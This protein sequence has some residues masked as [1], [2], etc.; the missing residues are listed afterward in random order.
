MA[1]AGGAADKLPNRYEHWWT[2][3]QIGQLLRGEASSMRLEPP[4]D[5]GEGIE[6]E[7]QFPDGPCCDQVKDS[8][9]RWTLLRLA[10][11]LEK[12]ARHLAGGKTVRLILSTDAGELESL[13]ERAVAAQTFAEFE[14]IRTKDQATE[15]AAVRSNWPEA[16]EENAWRYLRQI[17]VWHQPGESLRREVAL[18]YSFLVQDDAETVVSLLRA[19]CDDHLHQVVTAPQIWSYLAEKKVKR[20]YLIGDETTALALSDSVGRFTRHAGEN[21]PALGLAVRPYTEELMERLLQPDGP[22]IVLCEGRAGMGKSTVVS[23]VVQQLQERGWYAAAVRMSAASPNVQSAA[24]LGRVMELSDSPA[25]VLANAAGG[26]PSLLVIDQL[27]AVSTYSGRMSEVYGAVADVIEQLRYEPSVKVVL[28]ARKVD[29]E[30]DSRLRALATSD[31]VARLVLDDLTDESL[32]T[33]LAEYGTDPSALSPE[34]LRLLK[35]PLHL[36]VFSR[37]SVDART[38]TYRTLQQLYT[39]FTKERRSAVERKLTPEAW[40]RITTALVQHLSDHET[41][42]APRPVLDR[43]DQADVQVLE[44]EG[45]LA[46]ETG[47]RIG[48]FHESYFDYL[49]ARAF[50]AG[51]TTL[52]DFLAGSGQALFRRAQTRQILEYTEAIDPSR[53]RADVRDLL[54]SHAIRPHINDVVITVL[55]QLKATSADWQLLEDLAWSSSPLAPKI[56]S[57]LGHPVWFDAADHDGFWE[58]LLAD[59]ATAAEAFNSLVSVVSYR[60]QRVSALVHP[61]AGVSDVWRERLQRLVFWAMSADIESL[62]TELIDRG[63]L[64]DPHGREAGGIALLSN[65]QSLTSR[66]PQSATRIL[67]AYLRRTAVR[68]AQDGHEDP[69]KAGLLTDYTPSARDAITP[70]AAGAP[71]AF[72][73]EVLPFVLKIAAA[74]EA[75]GKDTGQSPWAHMYLGAYD[76]GSLLIRGLEQALGALA[77]SQPGIVD[78]ALRQLM[79]ING[80]ETNYIVARVHTTVDRTDEAVRWLLA[81]DALRQGIWDAVLWATRDMIKFVSRRCSSA[82]FNCLLTALLQLYPSWERRRPDHRGFGLGLL[83]ITQYRLLSAVDPTRLTDLARRR[84]GEWERKFETPGVLAPAPASEVRAVAPP[85]SDEAG[86]RMKDSHWLNA[87]A[88]YAKPEHNEQ[89]STQ[90]GAFELSQTLGRRAEREPQRFARIALTLDSASPLIYFAAILRAVAPS[91]DADHFTDLCVHVYQCVGPSSIPDICRTIDSNRTNTNQALVELLDRFSQDQTAAHGYSATDDLVTAGIN[92]SRGHAVWTAGALLSQSDQHLSALTQIVQRLSSDPSPAVRACAALAVHVLH[93]HDP[94]TALDLADEL[95]ADPTA[96]LYSAYT[97]RDLLVLALQQ[98]VARFSHYLSEALQLPAD[99]GSNAGQIWAILAIW[100]VL[101]PELPQTVQELSEPAR[102]GA[103]QIFAQYP[104]RSLPW[105]PCLFDDADATVRESAS[106]ATANIDQLNGTALNDFV[107]AFTHSTAF[108]KNSKN[109]LITLNRQTTRLPQSALEACERAATLDTDR[110]LAGHY[111]IPLVLRLYRQTSRGDRER[112]LDIIDRL[113][114][115]ADLSTVDA[116]GR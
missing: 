104:G 33:A 89:W 58:R 9:T 40:H 3:L 85:I 102:S 69:F 88:I 96:N 101:T 39:Q 64:D 8:G 70:C 72:V 27:D 77:A 78:D 35:V 15:F 68:A 13:C 87:L 103:A 66:D 54:E 60:P 76:V 38:G 48:F 115:T 113:A 20:R 80:P 4:G 30:E 10:P 57:L 63:E 94:N 114:L 28:V 95:L 24:A 18:S 25:V 14:E 42:S 1:M 41:L 100:E 79:A 47:D 106:R 49:F 26:Q 2:A 32:R 29:V 19:F 75:R 5:A 22:Q 50:T 12:V 92:T 44:S 110:A 31:R 61:Y 65:L 108:P 6:F 83:G 34:T 52:H 109:L 53:F 84:L 111:V 56:R 105:L 36:S 55:R 11:V 73:S 23:D 90:G 98:D 59:P 7:I 16:T 21:R 71:A 67:G 112:C 93:K 74:K 17:K 62:V 82:T 86:A 97:V 116:A 45:I 99:A 107:K 51:T 43:F 81:D 37:L 46:M 91:L